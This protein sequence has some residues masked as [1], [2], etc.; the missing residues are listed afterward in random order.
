MPESGNPGDEPHHEDSESPVQSLLM[1]H[2]GP[3]DSSIGCTHCRRLQ[4]GLDPV[5]YIESKNY[6]TPI[7]NGMFLA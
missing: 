1:W 5:C 3:L 2:D 4:A 7:A 6:S